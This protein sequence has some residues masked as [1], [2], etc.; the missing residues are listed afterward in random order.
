MKKY[1]Q[2]LIKDKR[3]DSEKCKQAPKLFLRKAL[4]LKLDVEN[5]LKKKSCFNRAK[6]LC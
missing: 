1:T 6:L 3:N 4:Q 5:I 2:N